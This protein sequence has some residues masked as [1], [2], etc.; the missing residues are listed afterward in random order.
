MG[1]SRLCIVAQK[2]PWT[3]RTRTC[4]SR[5]SSRSCDMGQQ[6][7]QG[8]LQE[9]PPWG[10][11]SKK[12]VLITVKTRERIRGGWSARVE[13][14]ATGGGGG[15]VRGGGGGRGGGSGDERKGGDRLRNLWEQRESAIPAGLEE[16][17]E[18]RWRNRGG[19]QR[20][21]DDCGS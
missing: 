13:W 3:Y 9:S 5:T 4:N 15:Q 1:S 14:K 19:L 8:D 21:V 11:A 20:D 2:T 6:V 10:P 18:R 16:L 17:D 12:W 7:A